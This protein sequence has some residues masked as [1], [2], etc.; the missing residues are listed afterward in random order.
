MNELPPVDSAEV[1]LTRKRT[2]V[3]RADYRMKPK[4]EKERN[5]KPQKCLVSETSESMDK[6]KIK[7]KLTIYCKKENYN[8]RIRSVSTCILRY[9]R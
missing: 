2:K 8:M 9:L 5:I 1:E 4:L 6:I 7:T 3:E